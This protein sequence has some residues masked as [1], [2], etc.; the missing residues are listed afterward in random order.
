[1]TNAHPL[2]VVSA[3]GCYGGSLA[4]YCLTTYSALRAL[5][6]EPHNK[7]IDY[8]VNVEWTFLCQDGTSFSV[9]DWQEKSIPKGY[10]WWHIGGNSTRS[11]EAF[12]RMTGLPAIGHQEFHNSGAGHFRQHATA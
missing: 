2:M 4:G 1:M 5:L 6:G 8:K 12:T 10:Y 11:L 7:D 9:Y 3:G